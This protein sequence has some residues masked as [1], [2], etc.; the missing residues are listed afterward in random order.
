MT[1][2]ATALPNPTPQRPEGMEGVD[3]LLNIVMWG[4]FTICILALIGGGVLFALAALGRTQASDLLQKVAFPIV[5][6]IIVGA[7]AGLIG[8]FAR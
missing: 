5:G 3:T 8:M 6:A 1:I 7:A 4:G 2:N